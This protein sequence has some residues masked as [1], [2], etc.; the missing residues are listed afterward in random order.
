M[1]ILLVEDNPADFM[2]FQEALANSKAG[3]HE[4]DHVD[5]LAAGLER[6]AAKPFDVVLLDL[7]LPDSKGLPTLA[8][9]HAKAG[10]VP[11]VVLTAS[12]DDQLAIDVLQQ[13][14]QDY[15]VKG[16]VQ[17]YPDLLIR[18]MRYAVERKRAEQKLRRTEAMLVQAGKMGA[19]GQLASGIAHEVKNPLNIIQQS[20]TYLEPE[21]S[22]DGQAREVLQVIREAVTT[23]DRIIRGLLDLSRPAPLE[24][25]QTALGEV[26]DASLFLVHNQLG[27]RHV[28]VVNNR[29]RSCW[30]PTR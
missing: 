18:S 16:V 27:L 4:I 24:L 26:V 29:L 3:A 2:A 5:R 14:A 23:A 11:I 8:A 1:K 22:R 19:I 12:D 21:L 9:M 20:V 17:V 7:T 10:D 28:R 6:V 13:G 30:M 15:L 25:K